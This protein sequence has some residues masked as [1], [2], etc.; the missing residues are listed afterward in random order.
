MATLIQITDFRGKKG[1][2]GDVTPEAEQALADA[3]A[4]RDA[5]Q[6][7]AT[8]FNTW[9][10][11]GNGSPVG[12][13]TPSSA[14]VQ[15][16]DLQATNGAYVWISTGTTASA[17]RVVNGDTGRRTMQSLILNGWSATIYLRRIN[18]SVILEVSNL[19]STTA[20]S[21]IILANAPGFT[22]PRFSIFPIAVQG[23]TRRVIT[24][25]STASLLE[26]Y[27]SDSYSDSGGLTDVLHWGTIQSWP[28]TLPGTPA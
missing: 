2:T 27:G 15:Y 16:V 14:G 24:K 5:A 21:D 6:G 9:F 23:G 8:E 13:V 26:R 3:I 12:V 19:T 18:Y 17:W 7:Y 11:R 22:S 4:A 20:T 25:S 1:D 10:L 28:T